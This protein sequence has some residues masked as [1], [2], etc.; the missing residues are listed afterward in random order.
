MTFSSKLSWGLT[1]AAYESLS[2]GEDV[3]ERMKRMRSLSMDLAS[4][5]A[6]VVYPRPGTSSMCKCFSNS[7]LFFDTK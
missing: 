7:G 1:V 6:K 2:D 4:A 3:P 5:Q